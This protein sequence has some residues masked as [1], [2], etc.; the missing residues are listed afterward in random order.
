MPITTDHLPAVPVVDQNVFTLRDG[1][2]GTSFDP[3]E[4]G[5]GVL[6][7]DDV[8][9]AGDVTGQCDVTS[10][11]ASNVHHGRRVTMLRL[12]VITI[13]VASDSKRGKG[14]G[15]YRSVVCFMAFERACALGC[16]G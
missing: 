8:T 11:H 10:H 6:T 2:F 1:L 7:D 4:S 16:A 5:F 15:K 13:H 9:R 3:L 12:S 14:K